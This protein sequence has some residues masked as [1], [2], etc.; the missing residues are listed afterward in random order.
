MQIDQTIFKAY[1]IRGIYP[2]QI[3]EE[4]AYA[5]GRAFATLLSK[6]NLGKKLKVAVGSDMRLSSPALKQKVIAGL[7]DSGID[8][9]DVGLVS[10]P[11]FY[12]AV[13]YYKYD[14]GMQVSASHN[15]K[16][17]NG[18]KIVRNAAIPLSKDAGID[19]LRDMIAADQLMPLPAVRGEL[20]IRQHVVDAEAADQLKYADVSKIKPLKIV[21]DAA[22]A[23]GALDMSALFPHLPCEIIKM[24]FDLDGN[25]PSHEADPMQPQNIQPLCQRVVAERA[26][27][28]IATDGDGDRVF[29]VD[30]KGKPLAQSILRGMIAQIVLKEHPGA[31]VSYDIRPGKITLDMIEQYHGVPL[32]TRVGHSFIKAIM[33]EQGA[34][35]GGESSGHH[36]FK[37]DYGVFEAPMVLVLKLLQ[38]ISEQNK[39][40]SEIIAPFDKYYHSGEI[41]IHMRDQAEISASLEKVKAAFADGKQNLLDGVT[42]EYPDVWFNVRGSNTEPLLRIAVEGKNKEVVDQTVAKIKTVISSAKVLI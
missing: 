12:F 25:F 27:L 31:K 7:L 14:G 1:D 41:N 15:P 18:L 29:F 16:E 17:W 38:F 4:S 22:N 30:E 28:G 36:A 39:P 3:N 40:F 8:V 9:D 33:I 5:I 21:V 19:E 42:V 37:L 2:Q 11:T 24:N 20:N 10:T 6:E 23:M 13:A 26:D 35:Y 34:V 32:L